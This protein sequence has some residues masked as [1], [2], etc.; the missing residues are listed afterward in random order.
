MTEENGQII[1]TL[2]ANITA[3][4][5]LIISIVALVYTIM[6]YFLKSGHSI[7][8]NFSTASSIE[9]DDKY[10]SSLTLE[11]LKDRATVIFKIYLKIGNN[12]FLELEDN[13]DKPIIIG[14]FEVY[15]KNYEPI[16]YYSINTDRI[17]LDNLI[18]NPK[19]KKQSFYQLL[20]ENIRLELILS[21]GML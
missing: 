16:V 4:V 5:A 6:A 14:P 7:R 3:L 11:N 20:M 13:S 15:Q 1:N 21:A 10:V 12:Y 2:M 8:G 9:C 19:V 17:K 18:D